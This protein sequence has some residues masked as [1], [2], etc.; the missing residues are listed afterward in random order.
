MEIIQ[1]DFPVI[2][3]VRGSLVAI[4]QMKH[5]PFAI[6]RVYYI[7]NVSDIPRGFHAHKNLQQVLICVNGSCQVTLD[8]GK[9]VQ[10]ILLNQPNK[11]LFIDKMIWRE[12]DQFSH[13]CI[14]LV[15]ASE[16]YDESDYIRHYG[17][18]MERLGEE[19]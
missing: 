17:E 9:Q 16:G 13:D 18:F 3:D 4:E 8:D 10:K 12:M 11:G 19:T 1:Y 5:I 15:L 14:L 7:Y 2:E 6:K